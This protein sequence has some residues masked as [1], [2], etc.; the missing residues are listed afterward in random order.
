MWIVGF[1]INHWG[2]NSTFRK[3]FILAIPLFNCKTVLI[4]RMKLA[5]SES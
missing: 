1:F 5:D 3:Y 2:I 4:L